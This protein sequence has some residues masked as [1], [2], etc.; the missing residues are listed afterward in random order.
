MDWRNCKS[1]LKLREQINLAYPNR[2][3]T[4]DGTIGDAAHASRK[5]DHNPWVK[6]KNGQPVVTAMDIDEDLSPNIHSLKGVIDA[7]CASRDSRVKYIIYE[8]KITVQGSNLQQWVDYHG[9][10]PHNHHAHISV[11]SDQVFFDDD[12]LWRI[13]VTPILPPPIP[14]NFTLYTVRSHDTLWGIARQFSTS[15]EAIMTLN[16]LRSDVLQINQTLR[17]K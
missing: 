17:V 9:M 10:N 16:G 4:S 11:K 14:Q 3:K 2:D 6:D 12:R 13:D 8:S 15:A 7:I 1:L 5:S